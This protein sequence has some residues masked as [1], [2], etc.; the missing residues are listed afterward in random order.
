MKV[1]VSLPLQVAIYQLW[2]A[3]PA[4]VRVQHSPHT[5]WSSQV[6]PGCPKVP[7]SF[8]R[9]NQVES[10]LFSCTSLQ[11]SL[12]YHLDQPSCQCALS[13]DDYNPELNAWHYRL[14]LHLQ[15][16]NPI[17][18][19]LH[20]PALCKWSRRAVENGPR[21]WASTPTWR[22]RQSCWLQVGSALAIMAIW[23]VRRWKTLLCFLSL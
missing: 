5:A 17:R 12:L 14:S 15:H 19:Q 1:G 8:Q 16:Q 11:I 13:I 10:T 21:A 4:R 7:T 18:A 22:Q 23:G 6:S 9:S 20:C 2:R 3:A